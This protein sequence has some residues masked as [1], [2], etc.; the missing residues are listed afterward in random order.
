MS[1]Q[2]TQ[3]VP[4][5]G[6]VRDPYLRLYSNGEFI[7]SYRLRAGNTVV[8][9]DPS[10]TIMV[11]DRFVSRHHFFVE[12]D[13]EDAVFIQ[14]LR[15]RNG[16][17]VNGQKVDRAQLR[18][19][20]RI[21]FGIFEIMLAYP[22]SIAATAP[23]VKEDDAESATS[24]MLPPEAEITAP[25]AR[26][27][28]PPDGAFRRPSGLKP[29]A[30]LPPTREADLE[31]LPYRVIPRRTLTWT[32]KF[33]MI[34]GTMI[35]LSGFLAWNINQWIKYRSQRL[36]S[37]GP[38]ESEGPNAAPKTSIPAPKKE[39]KAT[40]RAPKEPKRN[41]NRDMFAGLNRSID[42]VLQGEVD[43]GSSLRKNSTSSLKTAKILDPNQA[44]SVSVEIKMP[45]S[46]ALF[47][48]S[49][50]AAK[51]E[52]NLPAYQA[53]LRTRIVSIES[54]YVEHMKDDPK[55]GKVSVSLTLRTNGTV[56]R[57]NVQAPAFKNKA[58]DRCVVDEVM[59]MK[60]DEP[61]WDDFSATYSIRF[62]G[63]KMNF[64]G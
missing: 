42:S 51:K 4:K 19:G 45:S 35:I 25:P 17:F 2:D 34:S 48:D 10:A 31:A 22:L 20:D 21:S 13:G 61:P 52:F 32:A 1:S 12:F 40:E 18:H 26:S 23:K 8:G 64:P 41:A 56:K 49:R 7:R 30:K 46:D 44:N 59:K 36:S 6:G 27:G 15:S 43:K 57:A 63:S 28:K 14:D 3:W 37:Q 54:C 55:A 5:A 62:E 9:R 60:M 53:M 33:L 58:F 29:L 39:D 50:D 16:T 38:I 24:P 11:N 47:E